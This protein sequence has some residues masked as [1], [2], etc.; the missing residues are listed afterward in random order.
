MKANWVKNV[1]F[2]ADRTSLVRQAHKN[3][4]KLL[5]SVTTS[6]YAGGGFQRDPNARIIFSTYQ[7]MINL[8]NA[9]VPLSRPQPQK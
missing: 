6:I 7:T 8:I 2:L 4:N 9:L 1:L 3:F 5:P